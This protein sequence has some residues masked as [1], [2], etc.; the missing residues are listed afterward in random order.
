MKLVEPEEPKDSTGQT[1]GIVTQEPPPE[2]DDDDD[3]W[4]VTYVIY[5]L[6]LKGIVLFLSNLF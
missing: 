5:T 6:L 3:E 1:N 2:E 4:K